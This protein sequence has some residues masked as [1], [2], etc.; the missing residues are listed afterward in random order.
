[1]IISKS[2]DEEDNVID[3]TMGKL[4]VLCSFRYLKDFRLGSVL[5]SKSWVYNVLLNIDE[6]R[7]K[8]IARMNRTQFLRLPFPIPHLSALSAIA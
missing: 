5:K 6:E 4:G 1:M 8:Q 7:F 3:N 2:Y